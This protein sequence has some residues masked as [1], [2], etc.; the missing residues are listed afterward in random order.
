[1]LR[2]ST[3]RLTPNTVTAVLAHVTKGIDTRKT[4]P[5]AVAMALAVLGVSRAV[6]TCFVER[7][8][9]T[10]RNQCGRK[11]RKT[12]AFSK[13]WDIHRA[14]TAFSH[15]SYNFCWP[16]RTTPHFGT[17]RKKSSWESVRAS[18]HVL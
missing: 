18:D 6:N 9:G 8:N 1:M 15:F 5:L 13:D 11:A 2:C 14:A 10:D 17:V 12:Y 4:A 16:V 7:H 3:A